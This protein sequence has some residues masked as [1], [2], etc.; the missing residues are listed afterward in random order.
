[1]YVKIQ[2]YIHFQLFTSEQNI[3]G[4]EYIFAST[5]HIRDPCHIGPRVYFAGKLGS[6]NLGPWKM[7][8]WQ[9]GPLENLAP[10]V[11]ARQIVGSRM[12]KIVL[13]AQIQKYK[14]PD[15]LIH[16]YCI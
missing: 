15:S 14:Y 3:F 8:V 10:N 16:R 2:T 6:G 9:I 1:M 7:L 11:F 13:N 4:P 5:L 12:S